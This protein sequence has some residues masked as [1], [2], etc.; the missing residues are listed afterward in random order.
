VI[1]VIPHAQSAV[2]FFMNGILI[3][4]GCS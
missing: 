1:A 3:C 4:L 2:N